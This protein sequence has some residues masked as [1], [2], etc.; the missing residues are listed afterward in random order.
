MR[1]QKLSSKKNAQL[2]ERKN[3]YTVGIQATDSKE[4]GRSKKS[5][6]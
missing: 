3:S 6:G 5:S 2:S 1:D 4:E